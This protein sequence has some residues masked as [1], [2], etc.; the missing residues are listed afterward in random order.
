MLEVIS[1]TKKRS[2]ALRFWCSTL[3]E[4]WSWSFRAYPGIWLAMLSLIIPYFVFQRRA[5]KGYEAP[6]SQT[7]LFIAGLV[8][9]WLATD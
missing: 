3:E 7:R 4:P 8:L 1:G 2:G 5:P 6:K 9:L